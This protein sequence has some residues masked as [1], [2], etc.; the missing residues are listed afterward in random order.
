MGETLPRQLWR[1]VRSVFLKGLAALL[2]T[3]L[4]IYVIMFLY[5]F[6]KDSVSK[7]ITTFIGY[8]MAERSESCRR[9]FVEEYGVD[10][11]ILEMKNGKFVHPEEVERELSEKLPWWPGF[12]LVLVTIFVAGIVLASF[13]GRKIW[14]TGERTLGKVPVIGIIYPYIKQVTEFVFGEGRKTPAYSRVVAVQF[15]YHGSWAVGFVTGYGLAPVDASGGKHVTV[16]VPCSPAPMS[17]FTVVVPEEEA[18]PLD[19]TVDE[20]MRFVISCGVITP[21]RFLTERG[22]QAVAR[23]ETRVLDSGG[24]AETETENEGKEKEKQN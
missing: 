21:E 6:T 8:Q 15:P 19:M 5:G 22:V 20:A 7:P 2:P 18:I 11:N 3:A 13:L 9:H 4:T 23:G 17:G 12:V 16:F 10:E 24:R 1:R 14:R